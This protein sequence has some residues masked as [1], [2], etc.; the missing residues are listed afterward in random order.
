[1]TAAIAHGRRSDIFQGPA[2]TVLKLYHANFPKQLIDEEFSKARRIW[3]TGQ[4]KIARP[5]EQVTQL[6]RYGIVFEKIEGTCLLDLFQRKPWLYFAYD[7]AI[8]HAHKSVHQCVV[9]QLPTQMEL[10]APLITTSD[11]LSKTDK[12]EVLHILQQKH[13]PVLCH[14]DFHQGNLLLTP[15]GELSILDW[16]DAFSGAYQLD[17]ALTAVMSAVSSAPPHMASFYRHAFA[18]IQRCVRLDRRYLRQHQLL[19]SRD[20]IFLATAIHLA[21]C[22]ELD[23]SLHRKCFAEAKQKF[24]RNGRQ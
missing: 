7:S 10:F 16:M 13:T 8:V 20:Y 19:E 21:R 14:G 6:G 9:D 23:T 3:E 15:A 17:I 11:R 12:L 22:R 5:I 1:M 4:L 18:L 2:G 24:M